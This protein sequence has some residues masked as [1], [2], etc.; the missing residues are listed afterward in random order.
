MGESF[1]LDWKNHERG[2]DVQIIH[3]LDYINQPYSCFQ[4]GNHG[5]D[6]IPP[7]AIGTATN[8]QDLRDLFPPKD[9]DPDDN[10][11]Y[12]TS[13]FINH[14]MQIIYIHW[15]KLSLFGLDGSEANE[16]INC[17]LDEM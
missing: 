8:G 11:L 14:N 10:T 7:I 3:F 17:M 9:W 5:T 15:G 12:P 4:W 13:I 6:K 1:Y 16:K 2:D